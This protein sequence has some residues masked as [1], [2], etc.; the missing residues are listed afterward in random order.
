MTIEQ[1]SSLISIISNIILAISAIVVSILG[2]IGLQ[3]WKRELNGKSKYE[4]ARELAKLA[5]KYRDSYNSARNLFT[6]SEES[7]DRKKD[8]KETEQI[9][10][11]LDEQYSRGKRVEQL[12]QIV[13]QIH[14]VGWEA[15]ILLDEKVTN[16]IK[17]IEETYRE[18]LIAFRSYFRTQLM[19]A[20]G[21][22][23]PMEIDENHQKRNDIIY[24][25]PD[26]EFGEKANIAVNTL[27]NELKKYIQ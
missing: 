11:D 24:G 12:Y 15:S 5:F 2:F 20:R 21:T 7:T 8:E 19:L 17:P 10:F 26:D 27:V 1:I 25:T 22:I 23:N 13:S 6:Y 14:E 9:R 16:Y 4:I 3:Q 18:L